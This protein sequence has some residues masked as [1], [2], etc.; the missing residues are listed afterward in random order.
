MRFHV[1]NVVRC[2]TPEARSEDQVTAVRNP[3]IQSG[4]CAFCH[5]RI[6]ALERMCQQTRNLAPALCSP[7]HGHLGIVIIAQ[8]VREDGLKQQI[9]G[10]NQGSIAI[11]LW[12]LNRALMGCQ[13]RHAPRACGK[14][15]CLLMGPYWQSVN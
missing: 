11:R 5:T 13:R 8:R 15:L 10:F 7:S 14:G 4:L 9:K 12:M 2:I 3:R 6:K 1:P